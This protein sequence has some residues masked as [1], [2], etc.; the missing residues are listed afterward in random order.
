MSI[1]GI[2]SQKLMSLYSLLSTYVFKSKAH[3][4]M[5]SCVDV[6]VLFVKYVKHLL[7]HTILQARDD[8]CIFNTL[9]ANISSDGSFLTKNFD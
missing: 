2:L 7:M 3:I 4:N 5:H 9:W 6:N 8:N 1:G